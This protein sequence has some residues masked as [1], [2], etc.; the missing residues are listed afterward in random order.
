M[1][2][3]PAFRAAAIRRVQDSTESLNAV[4]EALSVH[5]STLRKWLREHT[6]PAPAE[7]ATP[8]DARPVERAVADPVPADPAPDPPTEPAPAAATTADPGGAAP[9]PTDG[10][11]L[12]APPV[13]DAVPR[14]LVLRDPLPAGYPRSEPV[15]AGAPLIAY[16]AA[17]QML[18]ISVALSALIHPSAG[19]YRAG[20]VVHVLSLVV[21]FGAVVLVDWYGLLWLAGRRE[22]SHVRLLADGAAPLIW[23]AIVGLLASATLVEPDLGSILTWV[24]LVAVLVLVLNGVW[25]SSLSGLFAGL[26][27]RQRFGELPREL[28]VRLLASAGLSQLTWWVAIAVGLITDAHRH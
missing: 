8:E 14:A 17:A 15:R 21:G 5:P 20:V 28:R 26:P 13:V 12:T 27:A 16:V 18:A 7:P 19:W 4:A 2:Y 1:R 24:K 9:L 22:L 3:T 25:V 6:P 23:A 11:V 10:A